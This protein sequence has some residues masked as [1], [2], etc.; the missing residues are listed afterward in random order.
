MSKK[1]N[2]LLV[3][4]EGLLDLETELKQLK[5]VRRPEIAKKLEEA[6]AYGDLSENAEY[7]EAKN[8]QG[9][10]EKR[11]SELEHML[12]TVKIIDDSKTTSKLTRVG[13]TVTLQLN[14]EKHVYQIV[15]SIE[16]DPFNGKISNESPVGKAILGKSEG[17][18]VKVQTPSGELVYKITKVEHK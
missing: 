7:D 18:S 6:I 9:L 8:D 11:I 10:V 13:S 1:D 16:A 3:T 4:Q 12:K 17:D 15:G 14:D 2:T 5:E